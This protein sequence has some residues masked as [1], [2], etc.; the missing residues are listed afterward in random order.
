MDVVGEGSESFVEMCDARVARERGIEMLERLLDPS[1]PRARTV[2]V[3]V[4]RRVFRE[5]WTALFDLLVARA[6]RR[7]VYDLRA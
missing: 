3:E 6:N 7:G 5:S 1:T 4:V 2:E